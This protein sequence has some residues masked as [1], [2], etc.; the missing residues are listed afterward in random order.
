MYGFLL[1]R[2]A[3]NACA[4]AEEGEGAAGFGAEALGAAA[5]GL[6]TAAGS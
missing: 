3:L 5:S 1:K 4:V 6:G 2:S